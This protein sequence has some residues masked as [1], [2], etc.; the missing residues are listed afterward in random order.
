[1]LINKF[2]ER[3]KNLVE[4][5]KLLKFVILTLAL[6]VIAQSYYIAK[7]TIKNTRVIIIPPVVKKKF[8]VSASGLD[9]VYLRMMGEYASSLVLTW[10]YQTIKERYAL[11]SAL[12]VPEALSKFQKFAEEQ[13]QRA[14]NY[15]MSQEFFVKSIN[16]GYVPSSDSGKIEVEGTLREYTGDRLFRIREVSYT[17]LFRVEPNG[18]LLFTGFTEEK[19]KTVFSSIES[20]EDT[21]GRK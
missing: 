4:E 20:S 15:K 11:F 9:P 16:V 12:L 21:A 6:V 13:S 3:W 8:E 2:L 17:F 19:S 10:T 7:V 14:I 1:M 5:N 18:K